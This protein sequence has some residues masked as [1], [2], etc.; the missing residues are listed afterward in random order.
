MDRKE[1]TGLVGAQTRSRGVE[2]GVS[3][4]AGLMFTPANVNLIDN[5]LV[6]PD[7]PDFILQHQL[8]MFTRRFLLC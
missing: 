5:L 4:L 7:N 3:P 6:H 8:Q 1:L 2:V